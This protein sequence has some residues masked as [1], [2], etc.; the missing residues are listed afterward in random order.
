MIPAYIIYGFSVF[1]VV[2]G[3]GV[4][5]VG[6]WLGSAGNAGLIDMGDE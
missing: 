3:T 1:L 4:I 2:L 6:L 5:G